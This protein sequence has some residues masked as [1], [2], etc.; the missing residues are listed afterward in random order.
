MWLGWEFYQGIISANGIS[1]ITVSPFYIKGLKKKKNLYIK[2]LRK[3]S[4]ESLSS[5][6]CV[7]C[8]HVLCIRWQLFVFFFYSFSWDRLWEMIFMKFF[9]FF[10]SI[11]LNH[12]VWF[13]C[14]L[15]IFFS[16][17]QEFDI[18]E[19]SLKNL[20]NIKIEQEFS[21]KFLK[22]TQISTRNWLLQQVSLETENEE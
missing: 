22:K 1:F 20:F 17:D 3:S 14:S 9:Q 5:S 12:C 10:E 4:S 19:F 21:F 6:L 8:V 13:S 2:I 15:F 7:L 11:F 16:F 18:K